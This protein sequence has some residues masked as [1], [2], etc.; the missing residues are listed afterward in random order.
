M[1]KF[2]TSNLSN[3]FGVSGVPRYSFYGGRFQAKSTE[4]ERDQRFTGAVHCYTSNMLQPCAT[5]A[6]IADSP[7]CCYFPLANLLVSPCVGRTSTFEVEKCWNLTSAIWAQS[8]FASFTLSDMVSSSEYQNISHQAPSTSHQFSLLHLRPW[9]CPWHRLKTVWSGGNCQR[10]K[11]PCGKTSHRRA[12]D[13]RATDRLWLCVGG[14]PLWW[15]PFHG[16]SEA[17][18]WP[19]WTYLW[20]KCWFWLNCGEMS[21]AFLIFI[22]RTHFALVLSL[23]KPWKLPDL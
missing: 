18:F 6:W 14:P 15:V 12:P 9:R 2:S 21:H 4:G 19:I 1:A 13:L 23:P 20:P 5:L 11:L 22:Q 10:Q 8:P 17:L 16:G 7:H 3:R